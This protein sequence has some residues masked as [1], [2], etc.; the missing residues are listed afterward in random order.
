MDYR[1]SDEEEG[2]SGQNGDGEG[3]EEGW[4]SD[5]PPLVLLVPRGDR[6]VL[7]LAG[8]D[9]LDLLEKTALECCQLPPYRDQQDAESSE[10]KQASPGTVRPPSSRPGLWETVCCAIP[11]SA[12]P[13]GGAGGATPVG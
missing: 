2:T 5:N 3:E 10:F 13:P 12:R 11:A 9:A 6:D 1:N 4:S 7:M 8:E